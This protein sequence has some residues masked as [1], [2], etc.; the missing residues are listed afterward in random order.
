MSHHDPP[1]SWFCPAATIIL[2]VWCTDLLQ[3]VIERRWS[4]HLTGIPRRTAAHA[5]E[6]GYRW[7][8]AMSP[9]SGLAVLHAARPPKVSSRLGVEHPRWAAIGNGRANAIG[10]VTKAAPTQVMARALAAKAALRMAFMI[11]SPL[12]RPQNTVRRQKLQQPHRVLTPEIPT[13]CPMLDSISHIALVVKDPA[14]TAALFHDLFSVR[15]L[16]RK[17]EEG[18]LE[19]FLRL[20][21]TWIA[22]VGAPVQRPR[23]GDHIAFK[24]T[25]EVLEATAARLQA[26]GREFIRARANTALY[27]F[28]YDD[29]VFELDTED[30]NEELAARSLEVSVK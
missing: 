6:V 5:G 25:P 4:G 7:L 8:K 13:R 27:F 3:G 20:G 26:M 9:A 10:A 11:A 30:I 16:E 1:S 19:T 18:H 28:D 24:A 23:T 14:K 29:H 12:L 22:L 21:G 17:D 2:T 15:P